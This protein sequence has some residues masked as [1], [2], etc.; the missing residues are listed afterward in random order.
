[1]RLSECRAL[2]EVPPDAD[3]DEI[4]ASYRKLAF[5]YHPDLHPGDTQAAQRF[6]RL[7]QAYVILK[8]NLDDTTDPSGK[9]VYD[10]ETIR[11]EEE[12]KVK[13][14][15]PGGRAP[16]TPDRRKC[17]KTSSTTRSPSRCSR[18][19]SA[20]SSAGSIPTNPGQ[21]KARAKPPVSNGS[22]IR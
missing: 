15:N 17:S 21:E 1:M 22:A 19:S 4:K 6:S 8:K 7:N 12:D 11:Q 16:F 2:L 3:L 20:S 14:G 9:K 13:G 10:A 18:T 5:K